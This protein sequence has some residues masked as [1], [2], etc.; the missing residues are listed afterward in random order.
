ML[1]I[2]T[3]QNL[4]QFGYLRHYRNGEITNPPTFA[5]TTRNLVTVLQISDAIILPIIG[6]PEQH[7]HPK[8]MHEVLEAGNNDYRY[9]P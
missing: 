2:N 9:I 3:A 6:I 7:Q 4:T 1:L 8:N 5:I